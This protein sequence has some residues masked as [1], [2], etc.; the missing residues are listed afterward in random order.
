MN[1]LPG[2]LPR[3]ARI[4]LLTASLL[5][6]NS[7]LF[8]A[9]AAQDPWFS[10][11]NGSA[12]LLP[13]G[14][15]TIGL[16]QPLRYGASQRVEL[17]AHPLLFPLLPNLSLKWSHHPAGPWLIASRHSFY[18]PTPL[19]RFL[20][21]EGTGG[22]VSPEFEIPNMGAWTSELLV[23]HP[24]GDAHMVTVKAGISLCLFRSSALDS[25][26]TIDLP[27]VFPRLQPFYQGYTWRSGLEGM[28]RLH[29]RWHYLADCD[30][31]YTPRG[32]DNWAIEHKGMLLWDKSGKLQAGLGYK[33]TWGEYPFGSQ[34]H[35]LGPL[36]DL[37]MGWGGR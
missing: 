19:L 33:L 7:A 34:W 8:A 35:L 6:V 11:S 12:Q 27:L 31:F 25:R 4:T 26:T 3:L 9:R 10:S 22:I 30:L 37:Q 13:K 36:L 21:R 17:S 14:R 18:D 32:D 20:R 15:W 1:N 23:T 28:G 5:M 24:L 29:H 16:F 2:L